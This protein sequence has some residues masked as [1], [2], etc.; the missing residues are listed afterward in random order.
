M[1]KYTLLVLLSAALTLSAQTKADDAKDLIPDFA[2]DH[3]NSLVRFG[4]VTLGS[5]P[6]M[7][8]YS[9]LSFDVGRYFANGFAPEYAPWPFKTEYSAPVSENEKL[10]RIGVAAGASI[11]VGLIDYLIRQSKAKKERL[12][13]EALLEYSAGQKQSSRE[14]GNPP[15]P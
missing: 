12:R 4:I 15:A 1:K 9:D 2:P 5:F 10:L 11:G 13:R 3:E 14:G 8:L 7:L 6:L